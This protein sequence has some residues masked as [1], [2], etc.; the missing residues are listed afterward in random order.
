M[1]AGRLIETNRG[2]RPQLPA[3]ETDYPEVSGEVSRGRPA[4]GERHGDDGSDREGSLFLFN[5][6]DD[7]DNNNNQ[8]I[9]GEKTESNRI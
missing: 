6:S 8:K 1:I 5:G 7:D 2:E 4:E 3:V 9:G